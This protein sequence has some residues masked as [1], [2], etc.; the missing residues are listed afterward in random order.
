VKSGPRPL[1]PREL[2]ALDAIRRE[3]TRER[4]S[5]RAPHGLSA[6]ERSYSSQFEYSQRFQCIGFARKNNCDRA[7]RK[8]AAAAGL[9]ITMVQDDKGSLKLPGGFQ[10]RAALVWGLNRDS[11]AAPPTR[12]MEKGE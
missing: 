1:S 9:N 8:L 2:G 3:L 4:R 6:W 12:K 5:A 10:L 7:V 11:H